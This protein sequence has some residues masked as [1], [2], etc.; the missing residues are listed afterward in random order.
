MSP[1]TD[2]SGAAAD[3]DLAAGDGAT[4]E[5]RLAAARERVGYAFKDSARL[6]VALTHSS[7]KSDRR[8]SN[9]RLEFLGDA[10]LGLVIT[11]ALFARFPGASEGSLTQL[12]SSVVSSR[13]LARE[14]R[15]LGFDELLEVG[16][17]LRRNGGVSAAMCADLFEALIGAIHLDGGYGAAKA[18]ILEHL[19]PSLDRI[20]AGG[21]HVNWKS[22]LQQ[23]TQRFDGRVPEYRLEAVEGPDHEP[24]FRISV[25]LEGE[26]LGEGTGPTKKTAQQSAARAACEQLI[27]PDDDGGL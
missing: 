3:D 5:D 27:P 26:R 18:W 14:A 21:R 25:W 23:H 10:V 12:K 2:T 17:G 20:I 4:V 13:N 6:L 19:Q 16:T 22:R 11:E 7:A 9:E 24:S 1:T 15:A 8:P